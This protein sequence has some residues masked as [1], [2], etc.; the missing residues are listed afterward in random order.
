MKKH[1]NLCEFILILFAFSCTQNLLA[2]EPQSEKD[3]DSTRYDLVHEIQSGE[4]LHIKTK[5][6]YDGSVI[7]DRAG[8]DEDAKALP[9]EVRAQ[10]N[11]DER[12][13]DASKS[14]PQAIR[15][16]KQASATIKAGKGK[17]KVTLSDKNKIVLTRLKT[18]T[19]GNLQYQVAAIGGTLLQK[20]YELLRN[21]GDPISYANLFN[22]QDVK[23]GDTWRLEK[24]QLAGLL[25]INRIISSST[26]MMLKL[27]LI[28]I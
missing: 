26:K 15:Q 1:P 27:S 7:V 9:L 14:N 25:S 17:T 24:D 5:V 4:T 11:F 20:E 12:V 21:P 28:H 3:T 18:Q 2:S 10:I 19:N 16:Y 13:S 22:K 23:V 6:E 8:K